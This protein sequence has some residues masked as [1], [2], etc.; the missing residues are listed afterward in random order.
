[1]PSFTR[2][3]SG[4]SFAHGEKKIQSADHVVDLREDGVLAVD[5]RIRSGALFGEVDDGLGFGGFDGGDEKIVVGDVAYLDVDRF[6]GQLRP[7]SQPV[8]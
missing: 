6:A 4:L 8:A 7:D 2:W 1:M 3:Q 5:H